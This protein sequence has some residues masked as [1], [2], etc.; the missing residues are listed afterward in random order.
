MSG[1][2]YNEHDPH[3]AAWLRELIARGLIPDGDVDERDVRDVQAA[4][5]RGYCQHH[6]FAGIG[7]WAYA[8]RLA[9]WPDDRPVLT[10]SP[11][12]QPFSAAGKQLGVKDDRHLAPHFLALVAAIRPPWVFG[13]QVAAAVNKENWLDDLLDE[14]EN[15]GYTTGAA[16]LPACGIGAP[17]IRQRLWFTAQRV[18]NAQCKGLQRYPWNETG[19]YEQRWVTAESVGPTPEAGSI[20]SESSSMDAMPRLRRV[21]LHDSSNTHARL[22]LPSDRRMG[23]I[24]LP[25][26]DRIEYVPCA[27]GWRPVESGLKPL[28]HG[29]P[30][31]VGRLRAYGNAIVPQV[32]AEIILTYLDK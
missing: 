31:R 3:A 9:G 14:L 25:D 5:L 8:L 2:Y 20:D 12:C 16:V 28:A 4:D 23:G 18:G 32:A 1:A 29:V 13:E 27:D 19:V 17:H 24:S 11:P 15:Q 30:A 6:F 10:G 22:R 7:G 21:L 26:W